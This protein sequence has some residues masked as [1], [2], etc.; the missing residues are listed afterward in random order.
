[1]IMQIIALI[2]NLVVAITMSSEALSR[3][4]RLPGWSLTLMA[5]FA[6]VWVTCLIL[7]G[8]PE[9]SAFT[10]YLTAA[11]YFSSVVAASAQ[12]FYV[13]WQSNRQHWVNRIPW[14]LFVAMP[15]L[16]QLLFWVQPWH[17]LLFG[18]ASARSVGLFFF[19]GAWGR[20][21]AL[22]IFSLLGTSALL[23]WNAFLKRP[24]T[25]A[26]PFGVVLLASMLP[27]FATALDLAGFPAFVQI[28]WLPIA[29]TL[30]GLGYSHYFRRRK[31]DIVASI[32]RNAVVEGM[33]DG[34]MVLDSQNTVVDMNPAA[35]R[36]AGVERTDVLGQP[37]SSMLG[38]LPNFGLTFNQSQ[39]LEMKRSIRS[40]DGWKYLNIRISPSQISR[41]NS[42]AAWHYG[43]M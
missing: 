10:L 33:D 11:V 36:M 26:S 25:I 23:F 41:A 34:W 16:T 40:E 38:T 8:R 4:R 17:S 18:T 12:F 43:T 37:V 6:A 35:E 19:A 2:L 9:F 1:M 31:P 28:Q 21:T 3:P 13:V 29:F 20:I 7:L 27:P 14:G 22:Y 24:H 32:D 15:I 39:E 42:S 5:I 30:T